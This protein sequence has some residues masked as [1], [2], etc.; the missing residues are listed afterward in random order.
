LGQECVAA[1][2]SEP[3]N[4]GRCGNPNINTPACQGVFNNGFQ[5]VIGSGESTIIDKRD[6][7][8]SIGKD[9]PSA[10]ADTFRKKTEI[11]AGLG[12]ESDN[13]TTIKQTHAG[14][15]VYWTSGRASAEPN[16]TALRQ[17]ESQLRVMLLSLPNTKALV[18]T[19]VD[20]SIDDVEVSPI[21]QNPDWDEDR[22]SDSGDGGDGGDKSGA[23]PRLASTIGSV[24]LV[25][26]A[27]AVFGLL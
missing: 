19:R 8:S 10:Q 15:G 4:G 21:S 12:K 1:L 9:T 20:P 7:P 26:L 11:S 25:G 5:E 23:G 2:L 6:P 17:A 3:L 27:V 24:G 16:I 18:C 14:E 13:S 22:S